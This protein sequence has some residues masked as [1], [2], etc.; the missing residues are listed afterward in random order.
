MKKS[1]K[2][3]VALSLATVM[4]LT[5]LSSCAPGEPAQKSGGDANPTITK[6]AGGN[7]AGWE[8]RDAVQGYYVQTEFTPEEIEESV[9]LFTASDAHT[10]ISCRAEN[11]LVLRNN[12]YASRAACEYVYE[13]GQ[14]YELTK[15]FRNTNMGAYFW[16]T[17][18]GTYTFEGDT[19]TLSEPERFSYSFDGGAGRP[20]ADVVS[21][22]GIML[23]ASNEYIDAF[24]GAI[25]NYR[26]NSG[27]KAMTVT[28]NQ[29][30][31][32]FVIDAVNE[33]D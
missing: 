13:P 5:L 22:G 14:R 28:I 18:Y 10:D 3:W 6:V 24:N 4:A 33:D 8:N 11:T 7:N 31:F 32:T 20:G 23:D 26:H 16:A 1:T 25:I 29:D 2:R 30:N 12:E 17:F 21:S 19:V 9:A 27:H 15:E